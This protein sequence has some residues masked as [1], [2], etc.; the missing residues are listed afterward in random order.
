M[1]MTNTELLEWGK[2]ENTARKA[3]LANVKSQADLE[4]AQAAAAERRKAVGLSA[5]AA[6]T[7]VKQAQL[8]ER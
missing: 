5:G 8:S 4:R 2:A 3:D 6:A 7:W 1:A